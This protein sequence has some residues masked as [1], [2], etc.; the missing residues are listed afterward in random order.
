M[1]FSPPTTRTRAPG[2]QYSGLIE[3]CTTAPSWL[4][5]TQLDEPE[6]F[7]SLGLLV[8]AGRG[9]IQ[10]VLWALRIVLTVHMRPSGASGRYKKEHLLLGHTTRPSTR[11]TPGNHDLAAIR[12]NRRVPPAPPRFEPTPRGIKA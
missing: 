9:N 2:T 10:E 12:R 11:R 5:G 8:R 4:D 6:Y 7:V 3:L 1:I